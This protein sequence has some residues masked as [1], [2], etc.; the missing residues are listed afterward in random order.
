MVGTLDRRYT[1]RWTA[2]G[3]VHADR[4]VRINPEDPEALELR[5]TLSYYRWFMNLAKS[6]AEASRLLAGAQADLEAAVAA[7]P[8]AAGAWTALSHLWMNQSQSALAKTAALRAYQADPYLASVQQSL[9]RL[10][11]SSLD[12]EDAR[13]SRR[14]CEEGQRRFPES[15]RFTECQL[16]LYAL[17]GTTPDLAR[18]DSLYRKYIDLT[19][20]TSRRF[21][22]HY[23]QMLVAIALARAGIRDSA[24]AVA[25]RARADTTI[26]QTR[27]LA[28]LEAIVRTILGEHDQALER[29]GLYL[30]ANPQIREGWARDRTWWFQDLRNDPRYDRLVGTTSQLAPPH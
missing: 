21:N 27:E 5:G 11:Q 26:D 24:D 13:E 30:S 23:G 18:L 7:D 12:L 2:V 3:L 20:L 14:W 1:E 17:K 15:Y 22:E 6:P 25:R 10:F 19:P 28:M 4:A 9:W 8:T 16:W 29:L